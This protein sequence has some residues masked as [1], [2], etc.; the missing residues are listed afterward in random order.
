MYRLKSK[1]YPVLEGLK[2]KVE[3]RLSMHIICHEVFLTYYILTTTNRRKSSDL[4]WYFLPHLQ[5]RF[6]LRERPDTGTV[7]FLVCR[8]S[9]FIPQHKFTELLNGVSRQCVPRWAICHEPF[10]TL[11]RQVFSIWYFELKIL[12][13]MCE[14]QEEF[15]S[16]QLFTKTA[17]SS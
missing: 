17:S 7:A 2:V 4:R 13:K 9:A 16:G 1:H 12:H 3:R 5:K 14:E 6:K 15:L 8:Y 10:S 11:R